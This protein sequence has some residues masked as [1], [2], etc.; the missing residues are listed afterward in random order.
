MHDTDVLA[1]VFK[2]NKMVIERQVQGLSHTD[3]LLQPD[4]RGNCLN[5][6]LGHILAHREIVM[7][8][9]GLEAMMTPFERSRYDHGA[10]PIF[11]EGEGV[12]H[13][14]KL[15]DL[16]D[17]S[18]D[19]IIEALAQLSHEDLE[20]EVKRGDSSA[21]LG[22]RLEFYSWHETYHVGQTEYLRQLAGTDD[23]V[24]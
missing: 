21:T 16:I 24:I 3:S 13:L 20:T 17:K 2:R 10:E 15:V 4:M 9:L 12:M 5:F 22:K 11:A 23:H 7:E 18:N 6:V 19:V 14:D 8:M 1:N